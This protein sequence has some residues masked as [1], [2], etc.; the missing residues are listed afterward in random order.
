MKKIILLFAC[1]FLSVTLFAQKTK[2][3]KK[4]Y[5]ITI[6]TSFGEIK[7]VLFDQTPKHKQNFIKL[8]SEG[9]YDSL[10]FHRVIKDFMIQGGDPTSKHAAKGQQ[11]GDGDVGYTIPAEFNEKIFHKKGV[12]AAARDNNPQKA[13]SGCQFYIVQGRKFT[14]DAMFTK[15]EQR[16]GHKIPEDQKQVYRTTGGVPHL[17]MNYTVF[18]EVIKGLEVLDK[19]AAQATDSHDRPVENIMM[20]ISVEKM[21]KKKITKLY[22]YTFQ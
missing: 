17:D 12:I 22:G 7:L 1:F 9:F 18:G 2:T 20:K 14:D 3:S 5:L 4:D 11:L 6:T 10:L 21:S 8:A 15:A 13:S 19:I 16:T